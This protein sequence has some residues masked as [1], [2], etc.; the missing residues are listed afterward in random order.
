MDGVKAASDKRNLCPEF[1]KAG[2]LFCEKIWVIFWLTPQ[3]TE[4]SM[5]RYSL[6]STGYI[7]H[8]GVHTSLHNLTLTRFSLLVTAKTMTLEY[9]Y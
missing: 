7:R 3:D 1:A 9:N 2:V 8:S 4:L 5:L 6:Y